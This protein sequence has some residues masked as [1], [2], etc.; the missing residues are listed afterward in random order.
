MTSVSQIRHQRKKCF[1]IALAF[2]SPNPFQSGRCA[3]SEDKMC[4]R[5]PSRGGQATTVIALQA[6]YFHSTT[7][8]AILHSGPRALASKDRPSASPSRRADQP[9]Q[10]VAKYPAPLRAQ[11]L[12]VDGPQH[13]RQLLYLLLA[14]CFPNLPQ[15]AQEIEWPLALVWLQEVAGLSPCQARPEN[16]VWPP[17]SHLPQPPAPSSAAAGPNPGIVR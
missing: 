7:L 3:A 10:D 2:G 15:P 12:L 4:L 17:I 13:L 9:S 5:P 8:V 6:R 14:F 1:Y 11:L 16:L